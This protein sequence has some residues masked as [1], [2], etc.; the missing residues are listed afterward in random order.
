MAIDP[1]MNSENILGR[2]SLRGKV[3]L[4][5]GAGQGIGR[6]FAHALADAGAD[7]AVID[8][9]DST[10][11]SAKLSDGDVTKLYEI[12]LNFYSTYGV[13]FMFIC[14]ITTR[15]NVSSYCCYEKRMARLRNLW[16]DSGTGEWSIEEAAEFAAGGLEGSLLFF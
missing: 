16:V 3:A 13:F 11:I 2:F 6:A 10:K 7:V 15:N 4:V 14:I 12:F 8:M 9:K 1:I 5:T